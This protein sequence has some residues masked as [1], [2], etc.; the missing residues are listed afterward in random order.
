MV[1]AVSTKKTSKTKKV[2]LWGAGIFVGLAILGALVPDEDATL[3]SQSID[4]NSSEAAMKRTE[5]AG[6]VE[7]APASA[8]RKGPAYQSIG[9]QDLQLD[10]EDMSGELI[11]V[12]G[13]ISLMGDFA[14]L[15]RADEAFDT[16][17]ISVDIDDLPRE[18]RRYLM[19]NCDLEDCRVTLQGKVKSGLFGA[20]I[21][22]HNLEF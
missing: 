14:T 10:I 21:E 18:T 6:A 22:P 13:A 3:A 8:K 1:E 7:V 16:N 12:Q 17:G 20:T 11:E 5:V 19:Q 15:S 2:L 9:M 4:Q